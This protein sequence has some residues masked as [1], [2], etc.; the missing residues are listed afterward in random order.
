MESESYHFVKLVE[1]KL[2]GREAAEQ[3]G[4]TED[5][6]AEGPSPVSWAKM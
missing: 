1:L 6:A 4:A 5:A 2:Q 3:A